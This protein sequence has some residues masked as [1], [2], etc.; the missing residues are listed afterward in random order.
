MTPLM[1][2]LSRL[3]MR[4]LIGAMCVC[5]LPPA[6]PLAEADDVS[7]LRIASWN[8]GNFQFR[9]PPSFLDATRENF[10]RLRW[11][12]DVRLFRKYRARVGADIFAVQ[13]AGSPAALRRIFPARKFHVIFSRQLI[14]DLTHGALDTGPRSARGYTAIVFRKRRHLRPR[15]VRQVPLGGG[16]AV[17]AL[18]VRFRFHRTS[19]WL[20]STDL[21]RGCPVSSTSPTHAARAC[22]KLGEQ[23]RELNSWIGKR[24]KRNERFVIAGSLNRAF[25]KPRENKRR[26]ALWRLID[27]GLA[28]KDRA[29]PMATPRAP[30]DRPGADTEGERRPARDTG[31]ALSPRRESGF[32]FEALRAFF[33]SGKG[34]RGGRSRRKAAARKK[35]MKKLRRSYPFVGKS[36]IRYPD[37][38]VASS[39][40]TRPH[41]FAEGRDFPTEYILLDRRL[42]RTHRLAAAAVLPY[43]EVPSDWMPS[44]ASPTGWRARL[45][46]RC[47]LFI[48]LK[49]SIPEE[50]RLAP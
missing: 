7:L 29:R 48:D 49:F 39:C 47:P 4:L 15:A 40:P 44:P 45:S 32:V 46:D 1:G 33:T 31:S 19:F 17:H 35:R 37:G 41:K 13:G 14:R 26:D 43:Q 10:K 42:T 5:I 27:E 18:A 9:P 20:I 28:L 3:A 38:G 2:F 16:G 11:R 25:G 50:I 24:R 6:P 21:E 12:K 36:L 23:L 22:A 8:M 30:G 34:D